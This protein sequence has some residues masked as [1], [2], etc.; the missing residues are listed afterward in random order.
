[1]ANERKLL[2]L[3]DAQLRALKSLIRTEIVRTRPKKPKKK[4]L[5]P[6]GAAKSGGVSFALAKI[7]SGVPPAGWDGCSAPDTIA[8]R[9]GQAHLYVSDGDGS[10][11]LA[12]APEGIV[13]D[14]LT[15]WESVY[16]PTV[17]N[18]DGKVE[19]KDGALVN[20]AAARFPKASTGTGVSG[21]PGGGGGEEVN[22]DGEIT[23][24][25]GETIYLATYA[26]TI[27]YLAALDNFGAKKVL[28]VD[29]GG[30][31]TDIKWLGEECPTP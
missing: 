12:T 28:A 25:E 31:C 21:D 22:P 3:T 6:G 4:W 24:P 10:I 27:D 20:I 1:M 2:A 18:P 15:A 13:G 11:A 30:T 26:R 23:L 16:K 29:E 19:L 17:Y 14:E 8:M 7:I 9:S 5:V